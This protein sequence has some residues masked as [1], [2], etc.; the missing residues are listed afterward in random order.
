MSKL[1]KYKLKLN[2]EYD[3]EAE[4]DEDAKV[5]LEERF[6]IENKLASNEF[7]DQMEVIEIKV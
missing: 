7:W 5:K 2:L 3:V 6:G 1:K 4:D